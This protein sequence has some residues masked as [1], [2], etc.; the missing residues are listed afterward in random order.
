MR[1]ID[2]DEDHLRQRVI[3]TSAE[4]LRLCLVQD[5]VGTAGRPVR[6]QRE[7][8]VIGRGAAEVVVRERNAVRREQIQD[9]GVGGGVQRAVGVDAIAAVAAAGARHGDHAVRHGSLRY[10]AIGLCSGLDPLVRQ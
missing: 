8:A 2:G 7:V 5:I 4:E 6:P 9:I 1:R 3:G 10:Q